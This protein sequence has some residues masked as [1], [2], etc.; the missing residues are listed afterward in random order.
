MNIFIPWTMLQF[1]SNKIMFMLFQRA[2]IF[3]FCRWKLFYCMATSQ[4]LINSSQ[5]QVALEFG[6]SEESVRK[7]LSEREFARASDLLEELSVNDNDDDYNEDV[8]FD[9]IEKKVANIKLHNHN[10]FCGNNVNT[11]CNVSD[12][13][14][15]IEPQPRQLTLREET[16]RLYK[17][18]TCLRCKSSKEVVFLFPV[19]ISPIVKHVTLM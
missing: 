10:V 13:V 6:Y 7:L 12:K 4:I 1:F 3:V 8:D 18:S 19:H 5:Y 11:F 17:S 9:D 16:E 14:S 15:V 2:F